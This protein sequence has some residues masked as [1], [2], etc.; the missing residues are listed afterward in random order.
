MNF[1]QNLLDRLEK[2]K[3]SWWHYLL[4]F[5]AIV[6][7]RIFLENFSSLER[8]G[9]FTSGPTIFL[10]YPLFY[11]SIF[12]SFNLL[13]YYFLKIP[14][15]KIFRLTLIF[16]PIIWL[17]PLFDL[18][19][20][21][22][23]GF[24][25]A[26]LFQPSQ[27]LIKSFFSFFGPFYEPGLSPGIRLEVLIVLIGIFILVFSLT[28]N[29]LKSL[30]AFLIA[31]LIFFLYLSFPSLFSSLLANPKN[32]HE[33]ISFLKNSFSQSY[34]Q[35]IHTL[36]PF[37]QDQ[38][39]VFK[40][41]FNILMSRIWW[42][43]ILIQ[44][45]II[46]YLVNKK[47]FLAWLKN[48]R[49]LRVFHYW[50]LAIVGIFLSYKLISF[51]LP[52]WIDFLALIIFFLLIAFNF[53]LAVGINDIFDLEIDKISNR[54]RPLVKGEIKPQEQVAINFGL[55]AFLLSGAV[56][57]N[58]FVFVLLLLFQLIYYLYSSFPLRLKRHF[59][60]SSILLS[61]NALII[62]MAGFYLVSLNQRLTAFPRGFILPLLFVYSL[63]VNVKDIKDISGDKQAGIKTIPV[64]FGEENGKKI[65][66]LLVAIAV[67]FIPIF[68][69]EK[70]LSYLALFFA[71]LF[72]YFITRK[73]YCEAPIFYFYFLYGLIFLLYFLKK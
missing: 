50:F 38:T 43:T 14:L 10:H 52:N 27:E 51:H 15:K 57:L 49:W 35:S 9:F 11:F 69:Q 30:L 37:S 70:I 44:T 26:Y 8:T 68:L 53:W 72:Y 1:F 2:Q 47:V 21:L 32:W 61:L 55:L 33:I 19:I 22:G 67:I 20:T 24:R 62:I 31:Y 58:Y 48:L 12:L 45:I 17:P 29:F 40:E 63:A 39:S 13:L 16:F 6:L 56:L 36:L 34:L 60:F 46:F 5:F 73:N 25:M 54:E 66:A 4:T 7:I 41:Q 59:L 23:K 28:K 71:V 42:L 65:I 3:F 18:F 64:I